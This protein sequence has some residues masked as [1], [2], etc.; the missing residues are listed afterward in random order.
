MQKALI[1]LST[2]DSLFHRRRGSLSVWVLQTSRS[3]KCTETASTIPDRWFL[4]RI[5]LFAELQVF[6]VFKL[7]DK[8]GIYSPVPKVNAAE[9]EIKVLSHPSLDTPLHKLALLLGKF[10]RHCGPPD[11]MTLS[12]ILEC[13]QSLALDLFNHKYVVFDLL[14]G[15]TSFSSMPQIARSHTPC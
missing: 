15:W 12:V 2:S 13:G 4:Y 8:Y 7:C 5:P 6:Q 1:P 11:F 3:T 14:S 9:D 10:E